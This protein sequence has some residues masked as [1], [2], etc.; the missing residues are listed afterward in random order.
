MSLQDYRYCPRCRK[1]MITA[2]PNP[3]EYRRCLQCGFRQYQEPKVGVI[4]RV[5]HANR[6]LMIQR[7]VNPG[8]GAWGFPGGFLNVDEMPESALKREVGE[9]TG[10]TIAVQKLLDIF[11]MEGRGPGIP[12]IVLAYGCDCLGNPDTIRA[13]DDA[14][15]A[16]WC[17]P[18]QIPQPIA[19]ESTGSLI[20]QWQQHRQGER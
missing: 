7:A 11:P 9:E 4:A 13:A 18:D 1:A 6:L 2:G 15:Q 14:M 19:F 5:V 8:R 12:G 10:L 3:G 17:L 20:R 16:R